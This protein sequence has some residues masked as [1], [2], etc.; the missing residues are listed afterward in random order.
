MISDAK[1]L[2]DIPMSIRKIIFCDICNPRGV[3]TVEFRRGYRKNGSTGRRITESR[4]WIEGDVTDAVENGWLCTQNDRHVCP[5]CKIKND[6]S[7]TL[8][9]S[10][11]INN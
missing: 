11:G 4:A 7:L 8:I 2:L 6:L 9:A 10:Q 1:Y 5:V 3:K